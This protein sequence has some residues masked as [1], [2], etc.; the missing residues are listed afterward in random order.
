MRPGKEDGEGRYRRSL[1]SVGR[2]LGWD[3]MGW[4]MDHRGW[5]RVLLCEIGM[6]VS[7]ECGLGWIME[8]G[9]V[10]EMNHGGGR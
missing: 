10:C 4:I 9:F 6:G 5:R 3:G 2:G 8:E 7:W 1:V